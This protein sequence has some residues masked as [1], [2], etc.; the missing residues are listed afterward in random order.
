MED[1]PQ[2]TEATSA[3]TARTM[4]TLLREVTRS[5][6]AAATA[7]MNHPFGGKTGTTNDFTDAWFMGFSPSV[8]CGVWVGYDSRQSLGDKETGARAA[9]PIW[10]DFMKAAIA[11]KEG[12]TFLIDSSPLKEEQLFHTVT[13]PSSPGMVQPGS[14]PASPVSK[15]IATF[16]PTPLSNGSTVNSRPAPVPPSSTPAVPLRKPSPPPAVPKTSPPPTPAP[17]PSF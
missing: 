7:S 15:P 3:K 8:T 4:M 9:L 17:R 13:H 14:K 10:M 5:G 6:T 1:P 16:P 2:V 11:G 12:E